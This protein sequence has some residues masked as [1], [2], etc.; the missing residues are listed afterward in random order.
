M[1]V[2]RSQL[3]RVGSDPSFR[4]PEVCKSSL[5]NG[6]RVWTVEHRTVPVV[7]FLLLTPVGSAADPADRPGLAALTGDL[8][9]EG[10]GDRSGAEVYNALARIGARFETEV[11]ADASILTLVTLARFADRALSL[12]ADMATRPRFETTEFA[13]VRDLRLTRLVQLR[14]LPPAVADRVFTEA[15]FRG[16]PYGHTAIGTDGALR[17]MSV[18]QV[19]AFHRRA[20]VAP[21]MTLI[22]VGDASHEQLVQAVTARFCAGQAAPSGPPQA[23]RDFSF[24]AARA[25]APAPPTERVLLVHRPHAAQS[26]LRIGH[27]AAPRDT[28]DYHA[29]LVLNTVLG[30]Q[31]VSRI[32]LN[33]REDKGYTYGARTAFDFRRGRGP[34][35]LQASV[36]TTATA[37]AIREVMAELRAIREE[38]PTTQSELDVARAALT[39][40]YPQRFETASQIARAVA[41]LALYE[42][43]DDSLSEF[44]PRVAAVDIDTVTHV[45]ASHLDPA[46]LLTVIVGDRDQVA[47]TLDGLGLGAPVDVPL[48]L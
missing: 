45:A 33:L 12:L 26:E 34:F 18:E 10:S 16:H 17:A 22:A 40:G 38:R 9:D 1:A 48:P 13:R 36:Q 43:P 23:P 25:P 37:D 41:Q 47:P 3:P 24:D 15:L 21:H 32:N 44:V 35:A 46:R 8:L 27:V 6:L 42:L 31:F 11:S 7:A 14:D 5:A 2:D 4:F 20:Y 28:P 30:A 29:L 39:R 19:V